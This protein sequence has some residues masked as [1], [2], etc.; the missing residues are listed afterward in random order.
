[1]EAFHLAAFSL[2]CLFVLSV[3]FFLFFFSSRVAQCGCIERA[4]TGSFPSQAVL[5]LSKFTGITG[6]LIW[7]FKV[8]FLHPNLLPVIRFYLFWVL[9]PPFSAVLGCDCTQIVACETLGCLN[10]L[11]HK[12]ITAPWNKLN[13]SR[14]RSGFKELGCG[15]KRT[16]SIPGWY[17]GVSAAHYKNAS[18][19]EEAELF[20]SCLSVTAMRISGAWM[21]N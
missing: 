12:D 1:M 15:A 6:I 13:F 11:Y 17:L 21:I 2:S 8:L 7:I 3:C 19:P 5:R 16:H 18:V 9:V 10:P 4:T 20:I 14:E